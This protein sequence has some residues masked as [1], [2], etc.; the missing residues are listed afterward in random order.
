M[1]DIINEINNIIEIIKTDEKLIIY[2]Q[3]EL[4]KLHKPPSPICI[5][6]NL[7]L[8]DWNNVNNL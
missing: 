8:V 5:E 2:L 7:K 6:Y 3:S 1:T 4:N